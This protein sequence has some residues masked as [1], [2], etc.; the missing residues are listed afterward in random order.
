MKEFLSYVFVDEGL[1]VKEL[2]YLSHYFEQSVAQ[3]CWVIER[4]FSIHIRAGLSWVTHYHFTDISPKRT[5]LNNKGVF[6]KNVRSETPQPSISSTPTIPNF[7]AQTATV[8][9]WDID[10]QDSVYFCGRHLFHGTTPD[11]LHVSPGQQRPPTQ[12]TGLS[13]VRSMPRALK[14]T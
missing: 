1:R 2:W 7:R 11:F 5:N 3:K 12:G 8:R 4:E 13:S 6:Q 9:C 14:S 10:N